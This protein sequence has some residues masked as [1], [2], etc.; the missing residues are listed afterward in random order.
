MIEVTKAQFPKWATC[1]M[2]DVNMNLTPPKVI[3]KEACLGI[4]GF[5]R[6][7]RPNTLRRK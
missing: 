1:V 6:L 5:S 2:V 7:S 4:K 3:G